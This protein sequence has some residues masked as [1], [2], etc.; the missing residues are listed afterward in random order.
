MEQIYDWVEEKGRVWLSRQSILAGTGVNNR[1]LDKA[2]NMDP[3]HIRESF[4]EALKALL[5]A[6]SYVG[7]ATHDEVL[8]ERSWALV[9]RLELSPTSYEYQMLYGVRPWLA[10]SIL[11]RGARLRIYA[12]FGVQWYAYS[13]RRLRENPAIAGYVLKNLM[14]R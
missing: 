1:V 4:M 13:V 8:V 2:I 14:G 6:G 11:K 9:N 12:P 3:E 5:E 7:I 10:K